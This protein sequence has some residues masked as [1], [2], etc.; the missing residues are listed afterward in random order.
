MAHVN[1]Y[2]ANGPRS[3]TNCSPEE[4]NSFDNLMLL[5]PTCHKMVDSNPETFTEEWLLKRKDLVEGSIAQY[6]STLAIAET[7]ACTFFA[8]IAGTLPSI[9]TT[10]MNDA[11]LSSGLY[12]AGNKTF[13][14]SKGIA[15]SVVYE[16]AADTITHRVRAFEETVSDDKIPVSVFALG[17][18]PLLIYLG[19]RL[20]SLRDV[21]TF[22][23]SRILG[24][25]Q[26]PSSGSVTT[27]TTSESQADVHAHEAAIVLSISGPISKETMPSYLSHM[28]NFAVTISDPDIEAVTSEETVRRFRKEVTSLIDRIHE[29][30]PHVE[31]VHIFPAMPAS[32]A[33]TLGRAL[34][35]N[36][37]PE[38]VI[39]EKTAGTFVESLTIRRP[40]EF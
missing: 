10:E 35:F 9:T 25:W 36:L 16:R 40:D 17:P 14:L 4:L 28:P 1:A 19:S 8:P 27:F 15:G 13:D 20:G 29:K 2:G 18:Q 7:I 22:Q 30:Y 33:V 12:Y 38:Y 37:I 6:A 39:H 31:R 21:R 3:I 26:W 34:R 11:L 23:K 24:G 32:L 5:C